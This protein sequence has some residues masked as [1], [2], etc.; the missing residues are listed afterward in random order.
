VKLIAPDTPTKA[1]AAYAALRDAIRSGDLAPGQRLVLRELAADLG[2]SLTPVRDALRVLTSQG[3]VEQQNHSV[4]IV[5]P[6]TAER[7]DDIYRLRLLLEPEA[8]MLAAQR[9]TPDDIRSVEHIL[10]ALSSAVEH[11]RYSE[12]PSLNADFHHTI[13]AASRSP[14]LIDFIE[15]LWNGLP[16]QAISLAARADESHREHQVI[17]EAFAAH[18]GEACAQLLRS[19]ISA[20]AAALPRPPSGLSR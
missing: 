8:I 19:H 4:A 17:F 11:G 18:D 3:L 13:Y 15:K 7:A 2:M 20:G 9:A 10:G 16:F 6:F 5:S 1:E 12:V 14:Y